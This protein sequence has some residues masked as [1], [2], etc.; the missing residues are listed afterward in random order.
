MKVVETSE[1][2]N[3]KEQKTIAQIKAKPVER[4]KLFYRDENLHQFG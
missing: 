2:K 4:I 3:K 1:V